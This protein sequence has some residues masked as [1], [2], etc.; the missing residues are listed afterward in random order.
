MA[1]QFGELSNQQKLDAADI[2]QRIEAIDAARAKNQTW[3]AEQQAK[4]NDRENTL[5]TNRMA[6]QN[7]LRGLRAITEV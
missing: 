3:M 4:F 2:L 6:L 1:I 7:Q 5:M